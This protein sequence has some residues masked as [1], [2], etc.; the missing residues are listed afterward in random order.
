MI[1]PTMKSALL[2]FYQRPNMPEADRAFL[3]RWLAEVKDPVWEQIAAD[4]QAYAKLP[5]FLIADPYT[6]F[7]HS[8]LI[9]R[10]D[11]ERMKESPSKRKKWMQQLQR[12]KHA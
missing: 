10:L 12:Q 2:D 4:A 6:Y 1:K 8:G 9:A 11:A 3:S 5:P 7:V